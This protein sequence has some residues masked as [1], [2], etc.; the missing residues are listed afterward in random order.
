MGGGGVGGWP[1]SVPVSLWTP[2]S[3]LTPE[4]TAAIQWVADSEDIPFLS[5]GA[6]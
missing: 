6:G 1:D 2:A 3:P 4:V 5:P